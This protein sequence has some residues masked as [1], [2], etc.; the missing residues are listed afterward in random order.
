M[1]EVLNAEIRLVVGKFFFRLFQQMENICVGVD[2]YSDEW[3]FRT[4]FFKIC[5]YKLSLW[6][7]NVLGDKMCFNMDQLL[8][9]MYRFR[10][11]FI[12]WISP[13]HVDTAS[14]ESR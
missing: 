7:V 2:C 6:Y 11:D 13:A 1:K 3:I 4:V 8:L 12:S 9:E 10:H 14:T 5:I